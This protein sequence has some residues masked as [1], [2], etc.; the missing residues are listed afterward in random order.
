[1]RKRVDQ[2][3]V[4]EPEIQRSGA[5][6]IDVA[7]RTSTNAARAEQQVGTTAQLYFYDWE[8][9]VIGAERQAGADRSDGHRRPRT[10][11]GQRSSG[12]PEYQARA[13]RR[14]NAPA[15]PAQAAD[16]TLGATAARPQQV[17]GCIY[18]SWYLLD[19]EARKDAL[20][21]G[22]PDCLPRK[23]N[24]TSTPTAT[25]R[26]RARTPKAVRVNPGHGGRC[27]RA[28]PNASAARSLNNRPNSWYVLND[29]PVADRHRHHEPAAE[30]RRRRGTAAER[31][32]RLHRQG[33]KAF[34]NVTT[35]DRPARPDSA[36]AGRRPRQRSASTS[37]SC[38]TT[39]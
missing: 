24:R 7:C 16:T 25:D 8:P 13:A 37:R 10:R 35:R 17:D 21:G 27:R 23:P 4:A 19:T 32:L 1:M 12:L 31:H 9:N 29:D 18:G 38:S 14:S 39:S 36:A 20:H 6:E 5:D 11:G 26:R 34:Q 33:R 15:D 3:G 22:K 30:L 2:L 28:R